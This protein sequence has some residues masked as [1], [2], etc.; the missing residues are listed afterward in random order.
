MN[1]HLRKCI[2]HLEIFLLDAPW[3]WDEWSQGAK[4]K[5][6]I[7]LHPRFIFLQINRIK[8][9]R[10]RLGEGSGR[11]QKTPRI[12]LLSSTSQTDQETMASL[13]EASW[14]EWTCLALFAQ[15]SQAGKDLLL[16]NARWHHKLLSSLPDFRAKQEE[17]YAPCLASLPALT[18]L[19]SVHTT[20]DKFPLTSTFLN[21]A[22]NIT[23]IK[24]D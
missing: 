5:K 19:H 8:K 22:I 16:N 15:I 21:L 1:Y 13:L 10:K 20:E 4:Y 9:I 24:K 2:T 18:M 14:G 17:D 3:N 7:R 6:E 12:S 23:C 11:R